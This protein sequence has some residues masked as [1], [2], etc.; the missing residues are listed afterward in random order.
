M[1]ASRYENV[2]AYDGEYED[3]KFIPLD[4]IPPHKGR[5]RAIL[6]LIDEAPRTREHSMWKAHGADEEENPYAPFPHREKA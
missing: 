1:N 3:G 2:I 6:L 5:H 4:E